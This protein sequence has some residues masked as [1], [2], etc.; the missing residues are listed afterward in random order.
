VR[1]R[2]KLSYMYCN[3]VF[4]MINVNEFFCIKTLYTWWLLMRGIQGFIN[5][6]ILY[7][8]RPVVEV[9]ILF[10]GY[11][12]HKYCLLTS[13]VIFHIGMCLH[14]MSQS[15]LGNN[16]RQQQC[17]FFHYHV[18][19]TATLGK[20]KHKMKLDNSS[21]CLINENET[22]PS[23]SRS[24]PRPSLPS[25]DLRGLKFMN[26]NSVKHNENSSIEDV[27]DV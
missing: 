26:G 17:K 4:K 3:H 7:L 14:E 6:I 22:L 2:V 10:L 9:N 16:F 5:P 15:F 13:G 8:P 12:T 18:M 23:F 11:I 19:F 27:Q 25:I 24:S 21:L 1:K 20:R